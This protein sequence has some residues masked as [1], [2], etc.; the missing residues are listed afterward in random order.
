[1]DADMPR[2]QD[3][4]KRGTFAYEKNLMPPYSSLLNRYVACLPAACTRQ[5][6]AQASRRDGSI[7]W[8]SLS[9][10]PVK[11]VC[12]LL[13][14]GLYPPRVCASVAA[15]RFNPQRFNLF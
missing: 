14:C 13:T 11:S 10:V 12:R 4:Q 5:G 2:G 15:R 6:Y 1:M 7:G 8:Y 9:L 3:V